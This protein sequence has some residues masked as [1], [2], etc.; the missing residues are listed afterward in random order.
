MPIAPPVV[1]IISVCQYDT[2]VGGQKIYCTAAIENDHMLY[3]ACL[4]PHVESITSDLISAP[5]NEMLNRY[6][7]ILSCK[8]Y[9]HDMHDARQ[10]PYQ[11]W[12]LATIDQMADNVKAQ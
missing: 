10:L 6:L 8:P 5:Q 1:D 12:S 2:E 3:I 9:D 4:L 7:S 11:S